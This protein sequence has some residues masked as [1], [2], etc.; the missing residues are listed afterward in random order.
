MSL[1]VLFPG[2]GTQHPDML[3]WLD[4][5][6]GQ[7][8]GPL[9]EAFGPDWRSRL[10]DMEWAQRNEVAQ[11]LIT[12]LSVSAWQVLAPLLPPPTVVVGYSVG[13]L[14][15]FHAAGVFGAREAMVIAAHR[16]ALMDASTHGSA[17][18]LLSVAG[19]SAVLVDRLCQAHRLAVAIRFA[20][21]RVVVG[22]ERPALEAAATEAVSFGASVCTLAISLASH[23]PWMRSAVAPFAAVLAGIRFDPPRIALVTNRN[24]DVAWRVDALKTALAEQIAETI[25]WD[26]CMTVVAERGVACALEV[27][28]GTTLSRLWNA[29]YPGTPA[30]SVDEF[31]TPAAVA[32]WVA[33]AMP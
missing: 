20:P 5:A 22:G 21:D 16:A 31:K 12:G 33:A 28:P 27:G 19:A 17:T 4:A 14:A 15:S 1:A 10:A 29:R 8:L 25:R 23:T 24:A 2:Q 7:R 11:P 9:V 6:D 18:G 26:E 32:R 13:E 30:R 3:P